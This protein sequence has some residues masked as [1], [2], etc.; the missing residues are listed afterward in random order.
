[1]TG[2]LTHEGWPS[3]PQNIFAPEWHLQS[4]AQMPQA[5]IEMRS[6]FA[7]MTGIATVSSR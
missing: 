4:E 1:M 5:A 6:S 2:A 3:P 7:P